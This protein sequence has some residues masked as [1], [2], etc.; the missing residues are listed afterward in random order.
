MTGDRPPPAAE[1]VGERLC[2][3]DAAPLLAAEIVRFKRL[4]EAR[5]QRARY[6]PGTGDR[7]IL[8]RLAT[9]GERRATDLAAEVLL[10]L[11]TV[12][13]QVRSLIERGLVERR[14]DPGDR[15]GSLLAISDA[16]RAAYE[17]YRRQRDAELAALLEPWPAG[18]RAELVRLLARLN[19]DMAELHT[20]S[21]TSGTYVN[22]ENEESRDEHA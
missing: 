17:C 8:A 1:A 2:A 15:R 16:G 3:A 22:S 5:M 19:D 10:D 20:R 6:E 21:S 11:S 13:R 18:E 4:I 12:S 9:G 7:I 14:P